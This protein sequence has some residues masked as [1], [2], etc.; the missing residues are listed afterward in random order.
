MPYTLRPEA[1]LKRPARYRQ[2]TEEES[3]TP[4]EPDSSDQD[5][6]G[7]D[8]ATQGLSRSNNSATNPNPSGPSS[9]TINAP[10]FSSDSPPLFDMSTPP[11]A[12]FLGAINPP[13]P[14]ETRKMAHIKYVKKR[15]RVEEQPRAPPARDRGARPSRASQR[16]SAPTPEPEPTII[17]NRPAAFPSLP[18]NAPPSP[19]ADVTLS[20]HSMSELMEAMETDD[21]EQVKM[22]KDYFSHQ[23]KEGTSSWYADLR[24]RWDPDMEDSTV[25]S[26]FHELYSTHRA[27]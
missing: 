14:Q 27:T 7:Q 12:A 1:K 24:R 16:A 13:S 4:P 19:P 17:P 20:G 23:Y 22:I 8:A 6:S 10:H 2:T 26:T 5:F 18:A 9:F 3:S 25:R 11:R 15:T 21:T